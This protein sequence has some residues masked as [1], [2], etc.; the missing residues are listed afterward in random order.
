MVMCQ[1]IRKQKATPD[2]R[3]ITIFITA[4]LPNGTRHFHNL[5]NQEGGVVKGCF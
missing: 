1:F 2:D 4:S 3:W 5:S